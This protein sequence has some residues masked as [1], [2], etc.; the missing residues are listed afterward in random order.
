MDGAAAASTPAANLEVEGGIMERASQMPLLTDK[1]LAEFY[2][3][4][5]C[6][7]LIFTSC[8]GDFL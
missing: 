8:T 5:R 3:L 7:R 1:N 4:T 6:S 2:I